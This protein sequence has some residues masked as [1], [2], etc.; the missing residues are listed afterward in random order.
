MPYQVCTNDESG[1]NF[2]LFFTVIPNLI[3]NA[4]ILEKF[5]KCSSFYK[6]L[7]GIHL[8]KYI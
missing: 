1:L 2:D 4:F 7:S 5:L 8:Y 3:H 6:C